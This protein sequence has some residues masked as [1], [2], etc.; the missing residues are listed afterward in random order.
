MVRKKQTV[1]MSLFHNQQSKKK[2]AKLIFGESDLPSDELY[3]AFSCMETNWPDFDTDEAEAVKD[4]L[5][6][7]KLNPNKENFDE[8]KDALEEFMGDIGDEWLPGVCFDAFQNT[9]YR[10]IDRGP[11][12]EYLPRGAAAFKDEKSPYFQGGGARSAVH[13][14]DPRAFVTAI[15]AFMELGSDMVMYAEEIADDAERREER[16]AEGE[17]EDEEDEEDEEGEEEADE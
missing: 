2:F 5:E 11:A 7:F 14:E 1:G 17:E 8:L 16:E 13:F 4:K 3:G 10:D 6:A 12:I 15:A 9:K